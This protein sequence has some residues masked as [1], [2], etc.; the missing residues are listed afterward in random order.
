MEEGGTEGRGEEE[1]AE[2]DGEGVG[3]KGGEEEEKRRVTE[4]NGMGK[5]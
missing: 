4:G 5:R 3:K 1:E 2:R